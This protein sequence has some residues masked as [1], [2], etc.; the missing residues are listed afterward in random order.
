MGKS[1]RSLLGSALKQFPGNGAGARILKSMVRR[2]YP[3]INQS[4]RHSLAGCGCCSTASNQFKVCQGLICIDHFQ[5]PFY[6]FLNNSA[7]EVTLNPGDNPGLDC[8]GQLLNLCLNLGI[9]QAIATVRL[10]AWQS[11]VP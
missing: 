10:E 2:M 1:S 9:G 11:P 6:R 7:S 8:S 3:G 5:R 4:N